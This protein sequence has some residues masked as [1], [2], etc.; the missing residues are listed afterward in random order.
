MNS[1]LRQKIKQ[2]L[3]QY[4]DFSMNFSCDQAIEKI[5]R[6]FENELNELVVEERIN[7]RSIC[8]RTIRKIKEKILYP[9]LDPNNNK[10]VELIAPSR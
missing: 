10:N 5:I 8:S 1:L 4:N 9:A 6:D 2:S 7:H 3:I